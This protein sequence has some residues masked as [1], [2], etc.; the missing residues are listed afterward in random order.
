ML[1]NIFALSQRFFLYFGE[2]MLVCDYQ[3]LRLCSFYG[4]A[5]VATDNR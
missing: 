5:G 2:D 1:G 4:A 3:W